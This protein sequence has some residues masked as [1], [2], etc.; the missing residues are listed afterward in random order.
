MPVTLLQNQEVLN[1]VKS[2]YVQ[3]GHRPWS[4]TSF[5]EAQRCLSKPDRHECEREMDLSKATE[6]CLEHCHQIPTALEQPLGLPSHSQPA[7]NSTQ[8]LSP[9]VSRWG[10]G[11]SKPMIPLYYNSPETKVT[12]VCYLYWCIS[13]LVSFTDSRDHFPSDTVKFGVLYGQ[14]AAISAIV[15]IRLW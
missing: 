11:I 4:A 12:S 5:Q 10:K 15:K 8:L 3:A 1:S 13:A 14:E 2:F 9:V 7:W 6:I